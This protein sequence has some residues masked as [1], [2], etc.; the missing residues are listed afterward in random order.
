M[1][2]LSTRI[3]LKRAEQLLQEVQHRAADLTPVFRGPVDSLVT[4]FFDQQFQ[5]DGRA[6]G[7]PWLPVSALTQ[8]LRGRSGH[9]HEGPREPL[10][11]VNVLWGSY[12]KSGGPDSIR[13]IEP[14]RYV[15]GSAVPYAAA[16]QEPRL[17]TTLFG[18]PLREPKTVPAR[19]VIPKEM[20]AK[21]VE[22]VET[23]VVQHLES[24]SGGA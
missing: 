13:V 18:R 14:R 24:R 20:P 8:K 1:L 21:F 4:R 3:E 10:Q 23:A 2:E 5:T 12:V 19:P 17:I 11:D 7:T 22:Q 6:G 9:G 16:H 15:R